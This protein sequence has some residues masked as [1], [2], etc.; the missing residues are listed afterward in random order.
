MRDSKSCLGLKALIRTMTKTKQ[1]FSMHFLFLLFL[2]SVFTTE[3]C[4]ILKNKI[5]FKDL[6]SNLNPI[7]IF[8]PCIVVSINNPMTIN[9]LGNLC[10]FIL[11]LSILKIVS[12][13]FKTNFILQLLIFPLRNVVSYV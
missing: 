5:V 11:D 6:K 7:N 8:Y 4:Q 2:L 13:D 3:V 12:Q 9:L 1:I 10:V